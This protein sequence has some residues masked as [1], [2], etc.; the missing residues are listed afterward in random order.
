MEEEEKEFKAVLLSEVRG[1]GIFLFVFSKGV[2]NCAVFLK[3]FNHF[4]FYQR[5]SSL[6]TECSK[7]SP[8]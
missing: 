2:W 1:G 8:I 5:L 6:L 4:E 7:T 3:Q